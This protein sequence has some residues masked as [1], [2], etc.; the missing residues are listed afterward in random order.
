MNHA[1][2]LIHSPLVGP[3]TWRGTADALERKGFKALVPHLTNDQHTSQSYAKQHIQAIQAAYT[4]HLNNQAVILVAHSG[5]GALLPLAGP[6]VGK[7]A[8]YIFVDAGLPHHNKSRLDLFPPSEAAN[9]RRNAV[10]GFIPLWSEDTLANVIPDPNIRHTFVSEFKP[11]PLAL[12]EEKIDVPEDWPDAPC[13]YLSFS[14]STSY[15]ED[16]AYAQQHGWPHIE[17]PGYHFHPL[18]K[19]GETADALIALAGQIVLPTT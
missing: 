8:G 9:F 11:V 10:G 7:P 15:A 4:E 14:H 2:L 18:V 6:A 13:A 19:P 3:F 1:F 16:I 17:L 5:A 12:Y